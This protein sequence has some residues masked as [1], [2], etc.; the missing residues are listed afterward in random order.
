MALAEIQQAEVSRRLGAFCETRVPPSVRSK[1]RL[2]FRIKGT[3]VVLFEERPAFQSPH[4]WREMAIAK[5][6]YVGTQRL[7]RLYCQ[8]RD[9]RW[10]SYEALPAAS[11]FKRLL[12]EVTADPT[13]I[14]WG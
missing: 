6:R 14:F 11:N 3:E 13:G 1:V 10:H 9:L 12:D 5:F 8:H 2:G 4:E 7:W